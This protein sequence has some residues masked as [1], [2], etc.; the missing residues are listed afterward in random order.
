MKSTIEEPVKH[1]ST[2]RDTAWMHIGTCMHT[3]QYSGDIMQHTELYSD[4]QNLCNCKDAVIES[5]IICYCWK[6]KG[7]IVVKLARRLAIT[8]SIYWYLY[9]DLAWTNHFI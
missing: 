2:F 1:V 9:Y 3:I 7:L 4:A 5:I 6:L 8:V